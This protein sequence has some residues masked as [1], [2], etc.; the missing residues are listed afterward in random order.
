MS[1]P[2]VNYFVEGV[3]SIIGRCR[4]EWDM[5]YCE[6]VGCLEIIKANLIEESLEDEDETT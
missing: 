5:S 4:Q 2:A 1:E 3:E 6:I